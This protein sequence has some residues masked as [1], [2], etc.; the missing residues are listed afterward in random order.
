MLVSLEEME[1][2]RSNDI[3]RGDGGDRCDRGDGIA[4]VDGGVRR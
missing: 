1:V 2:L 3:V 4:G